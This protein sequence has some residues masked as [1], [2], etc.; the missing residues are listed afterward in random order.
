MRD[1]LVGDPKTFDPPERPADEDEN[2]T[3]VISSLGWGSSAPIVNWTP[4]EPFNLAE[5]GGAFERSEGRVVKMD[6]A[7]MAMFSRMFGTARDLIEKNPQLSTEQVARQLHDEIF[8]E[9]E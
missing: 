7:G 5:M 9:I 2:S 3:T 6:P 4:N 8:G 1:E